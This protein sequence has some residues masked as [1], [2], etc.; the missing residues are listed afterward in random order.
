MLRFLVKVFVHLFNIF[1][2]R[3]SASLLQIAISLKQSYVKGKKEHVR[4]RH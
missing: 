2:S 3:K 1:E 4:R